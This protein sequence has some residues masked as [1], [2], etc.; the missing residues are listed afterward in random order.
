MARFAPDYQKAME[1]MMAVAASQQPP[2]PNNVIE[3]RKEL[4]SLIAVAYQSPP[5][6]KD[7]TQT[8]F[9]V[10]VSATN[11]A[12][13]V[14]RFATAAQT[15]AS[16]QPAAIYLHP[17]G[18]VCASVKLL[19]PSIANETAQ[20][21]VQHWAVEYSKSP[22]VEAPV[23]LEE[24]YAVLQWL[25]KH[26]AELGIDNTRIGVAGSSAGGG[27]AAGLGL[28]AR[29]RGFA[30][31]IAK[32]IM[33]YPMLDDRTVQAHP[34]KGARHAGGNAADDD[35]AVRPLLTWTCEQNAMAW[36]AYLGVGNPYTDDA[37][38]CAANLAKASAIGT[39][40]G[41]GTAAMYAIP[42]RAASLV[43]LPS[44]YIDVGGLDLFTEECVQFAARLARDQVD[45]DLHV[46]NGVPHSFEGASD[47]NAAKTALEQ[48]RRAFNS[49]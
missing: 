37:L 33:I 29:D 8:V 46:F 3:L 40:P 9:E 39:G 24:A 23:A 2:P 1:P 34:P 20:T 13:I 49:F 48:R 27:L 26:S 4:D 17:G 10:P 18:M 32:L 31:P 22:E 12:V 19:A 43:G 42:A 38:T 41:A 16:S 7:I 14:T 44:S 36:A 5:A 6:P 35:W 45:F 15:A 47:T 11:K 21:G 28:L 25:S 30:P